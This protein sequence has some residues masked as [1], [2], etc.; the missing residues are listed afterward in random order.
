M[1]PTFII[2]GAMKCGTTSLYYYLNKHPEISMSEIK[3]LDYF[4]AEKNYN[5]GMKWYESNFNGQARAYG[6]ASTNYTKYP[7]FRGVPQ[8]MHSVV[9]DAKLIYVVRDPIDRIISHYIHNYSKGKENG[10]ISEVLSKLDNNH[11]VAVSK[12]YMQ[13]K[14]YLSYYSKENMLII[15]AEE[16][17]EQRQSTLKTIFRFLNVDD[18]FYSSE[19][20]D[21]LH[22][23]SAKR[24]KNIIG[25]Y[26]LKTKLKK[27]LRPFLPSSV[28]Q[29]L[30]RISGPSVE[31]PEL[32]EVLEKKL[33][34]YL[35]DDVRALRK[36]TGKEFKN[37]R[38]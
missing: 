9:P 18:S 38:L 20:S 19:Y 3:E 24:R 13:V 14:Q 33:I 6:E 16:L 30:K 5:K 37:W 29:K 21:V 7:T 28:V 4:V 34:G 2:I 32:D 31:R 12:Y 8:R 17:R 15:A 25:R 27:K 26:L 1:S 36:F 23:S 35:Q 22:K 11:Y 10:N